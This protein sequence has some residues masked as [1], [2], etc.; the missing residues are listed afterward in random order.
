MAKEPNLVL[1]GSV[2]T[3]RVSIPKPLREL[4]TAAGTKA[5]PKELWR[6]TGESDLRRAKLARARL[7]IAVHAEFDLEI[8]RLE[9]EAARRAE[10]QEWQAV[11]P[12]LPLAPQELLEAAAFPM[13]AEEGRALL[14]ELER[15]PGASDAVRA[16]EV[17]D[18]R[19]AELSVKGVAGLALLGDKAFFDAAMA[20]ISGRELLKERRELLIH[21]LEECLSD[22]EFRLIA[23]AVDAFER[24]HRVRVPLGTAQYSLLATRLMQ[25]WLHALRGVEARLTA[26]LQTSPISVLPSAAMP[27]ARAPLAG[28]RETHGWEDA[29][30]LSSMIEPY[31]VERHRDVASATNDKIRSAIRQFIEVA[32]DRP[33][34]AYSKREMR[35]FKNALGQLPPNATRDYPGLTVPQVLRARPKGSPTISIKTIKDKLSIISVFGKWL[36]DNVDD[37]S[38]E[39]FQTT[40]VKISQGK[41]DEKRS[42]FSDQQVRQIFMSTP[43]T[44][45]RSEQDQIKPGSHRIR[46][47]RFWVPLIAA[48]TGARLNEIAQLKIVDVTEVG[49]LY[50]FKLTDEGEGQSLKT[51]RSNRTVPVHS[52]LIRLGFLDFVRRAKERGQLGLFEDV[53]RDKDGRHSTHIGRTF[54]KLLVRIDVKISTEQGGLHRFRHGVATKL[55]EAG[56]RD[57]EIA[58]VLG[59][60]TGGPRMTAHYGEGE[61]MLLVKRSEMV[62]SISYEGLILSP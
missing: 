59:H 4:R 1:R 49:A 17:A 10:S 45:C 25:G 18:E 3:L 36:A 46:D 33:V 40:S 19:E 32:G 39:T 58:L 47:W 60:E 22:G 27:G 9:R 35:E 26:P 48:F 51:K 16:R 20:S 28:T 13:A 62:E 56:Y 61:E 14:R 5:N 30:T 12:R 11:Y 44:G 50:C 15:A 41:R 8:A 55:R 43:F 38:P 2:W 42:Q 52:Q 24:Q 6:S 37:V 34:T 31:M 53:P 57:D 54:R 23:W 21:H 7:L 29:P